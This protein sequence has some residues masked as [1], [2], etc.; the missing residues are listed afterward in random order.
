[1]LSICGAQAQQIRVGFHGGPGF[2]QLSNYREI[3]N[4]PFGADRVG[5]LLLGGNVDFYLGRRVAVSTGL[6]YVRKGNKRYDRQQYYHYLEIP[7]SF[8][9][10]FIG[11]SDRKFLLFARA[12]TYLAFLQQQTGDPIN[13]LSSFYLLEY[14]P[15][16]KF[17]FG[18][19][20]GL[21]TNIRLSDQVALSAELRLD[22]GL[23]DVFGT[24]DCLGCGRERISNV[25]GWGIFGLSYLIP[26][27]Y[28]NGK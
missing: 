11:N 20:A 1:M 15:A 14:S 5:S 26:S 17:D 21:G 28:D 23:S 24:P 6:D 22:R 19:T 3:K 13:S 27:P 4:D 9:I 2:A 8:R 7:F 25:S 18:L 16:R 12:G 10:D